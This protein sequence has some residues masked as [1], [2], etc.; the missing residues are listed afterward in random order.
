MLWKEKK[1][2]RIATYF[3]TL[4]PFAHW[5]SLKPRSLT[6]MPKSLTAISESSGAILESSAIVLR[7]STTIS[8]LFGS[9][10]SLLPPF[11]LFTPSTLFDFSISALPLS[12]SFVSLLLLSA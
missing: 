1:E 6:A 9:S 3:A 4:F 10:I 12:G 5:L 2:S 7:F 11:T 8:G